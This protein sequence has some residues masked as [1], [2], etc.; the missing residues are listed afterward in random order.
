M[1]FVCVQLVSGPSH[2]KMFMAASP[3]E[4]VT[5]WSQETL[6]TGSLMYHQHSDQEST[7]DQ[8][9]FTVSDGWVFI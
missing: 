6:D 1:C 8:F 9:T 7:S 3:E 4:T 2:G 5:S